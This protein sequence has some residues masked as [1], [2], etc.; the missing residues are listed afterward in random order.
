MHSDPEIP[1]ASTL[2]R[3][4][5]GYRV[6]SILEFWARSRCSMGETDDGQSEA[7]VIV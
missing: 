3:R 1:Q 4:K 2:S 6:W 7:A 5:R